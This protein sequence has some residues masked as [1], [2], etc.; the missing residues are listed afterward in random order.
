MPGHFE[1]QGMGFN[2][3]EDYADWTINFIN[4]N[5]FKNVTL[6]GHSMGSG[7][8]MQIALS[9]PC[10][11]DKLI[12]VG[13]GARLRVVPA[14]LEG[15]KKDFK[16]TL[17]E[18]IKWT[19]GPNTNQTIIEKYIGCLEKTPNN[20]TLNDYIACDKFDIIDKVSEIKYPALIIGADNDILTPLKY[21]QFLNEK[22]KDS[23]FKIIKNAG[24]SMAIE[25][26]EIFAKLITEFL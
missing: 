17:H 13:A 19:F 5:K 21:G 9:E 15:L 4:E 7:I 18:G 8:C 23:Q 25:F 11:L 1:N 3:I 26:P 10:W 22:I 14:F 12:L 20:I 16:N 2:K 24:H 6:C